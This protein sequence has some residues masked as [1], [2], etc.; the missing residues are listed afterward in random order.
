MAK[1]VGIDLGTTNSVV[2]A[3]ME[4][5][6]AEVV[7]NAEGA[8][9]TPSV[10]AFTEDGERLVGQVAKRQAILNP[11]ATV[12]S[13]KRF[14]GRKWD[15]VTEEAKI[16]SYRVVRGPNDA[17]RFEIRGRQYSPE[18]VSALILRKLRDDAASVARRAGHRG[19]D[20]GAG[21]LQRRAAA[22]DHGR[23]SDR[24]PGRSCGSSTS[25][26]PPRWPTGFHERRPGRPSLVFDLGG[27]TFDVSV[28]DLVDGVLEVRA[29]TGESILGGED[30]TRRWSLDCMAD[31]VRERS[32]DRGAGLRWRSAAAPAVRAGQVSS[33]RSRTQT[34]I[35][36]PCHHGRRERPPSTEPDRHPRP[37]RA[38]GAASDR[39]HARCRSA[40]AG[41]RE[42]DRRRHR[43][44][45]P[46]R[47]GDADA[48]GPALVRELTVGKDP[49]VPA[50]PGRGGGA[51]GRAS[52]PACSRAR[53]R[54]SCCSTSSRCRWGWRRWAA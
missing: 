53:S 25:R 1:A 51:R 14:I 22:G 52:R 5:G 31:R 33:C 38:V 48:G 13:A 29:S 3:T 50:E 10:V 15:E 44:G 42:A 30:F 9:T 45:D 39:A 24:R 2:A 11:E 23:G 17:V 19:G 37:V 18:E 36:L 27:G 28:V 40:G 16:V 34:P 21:V 43:R 26:P 6:R 35:D 32:G 49:H 41:G 47:R 20:H 4:G 8:R 7:P 54:M 12:Y 46:G